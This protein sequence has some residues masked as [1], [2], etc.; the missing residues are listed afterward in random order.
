MSTNQ[1]IK[2][3]ATTREYTEH[4]QQ[5]DMAK[6]EL[7]RYCDWCGRLPAWCLCEDLVKAAVGK[8]RMDCMLEVVAAVSNPMHDFTARAADH[9]ERQARVLLGDYVEFKQ[10]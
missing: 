8:K 10:P 5:T 2:S 1:T 4:Y 9:A 6:P 7:A 3:H